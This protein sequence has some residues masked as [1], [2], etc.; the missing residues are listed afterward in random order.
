MLSL[1]D[2]IFFLYYAGYHYVQ[3]STS[4]LHSKSH[5]STHDFQIMVNDTCA[6]LEHYGKYHISSLKQLIIIQSGRGM[7]LYNFAEL[8]KEERRY[9]VPFKQVLEGGRVV[10]FGAGLI[11]QQIVDYLKTSSNYK[12]VRWIDSNATNNMN[13]K[14]SI[15]EVDDIRN[16]EYDFI[17]IAT[18]KKIYQN[19]MMQTLKEMNISMTKVVTIDDDNLV[20]S[21]YD[22]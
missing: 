8:Q 16:D 15:C 2:N 17:V 1:T 22:E 10:V 11:G 18:T 5:R 4:I 14:H 12:L 19:Q 6:F 3:R 20:N 9:L 21:L 7:M 13:L